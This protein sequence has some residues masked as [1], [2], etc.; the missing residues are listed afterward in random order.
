MN[1]LAARMIEPD[2]EVAIPSESRPTLCVDLDHTLL[3]TD[4]LYEQIALLARQKPAALL[5]L[6][7]WASHGRAALKRRLAKE[8]KLDIGSL[9]FNEE[10]LAWLSEERAQGRRMALYSA[11]D[12]TVVAAVAHH[13]G[14]FDSWAG[15]DGVDNLA[16]SRKAQA[17]H[18]AFGSNFVYAGDHP[19]DVPVFAAGQGAVYVGDVDDLAR[20]LP[21]DHPVEAS[22]PGQSG[23]LKLWA[24]QLRLHQ[25]TKNLLVFVPVLLAGRLAGGQEYLAS[26]LAFFMLSFLASSG[27]VLNDLLDLEADRGHEIKRTRPF[28]SGVLK[29]RDGL[30]AFP[31]LLLAGLGMGLFLPP[32]AIAAGGLYLATTLA[33][34][35]ALKREP[36]LDVMI[37]AGLFTIRLLAGAFAIELPISY[38]L[39]TFS[40]FIFTSLAVVK[41]YAELLKLARRQG[42]V[43]A[44]RGYSTAD[45][46]LLLALGVGTAVAACVIFIIYLINEHFSRAIYTEPGWLWL[47][48]PILHYWLMRVWYLAVHGQ[49]NED[50]VVFAMTDRTSWLLGLAV[51]AVLLLAW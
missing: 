40:M 50:P 25:W 12:E 11:S 48:F 24:K 9:P 13:L 1:A 37:L 35:F 38:W 43:L 44:H 18:E 16:G 17:I 34:S 32:A 33:Y 2:V 42:T 19:R 41:R 8:V 26:V 23:T 6:P 31:L 29:V 45:L 49:M 22:F 14:L 15:S 27:Y 28:A 21:H 4:I 5:A 20:R 39:L 47:A 51:V 7:F 36:M 30:V 46:G 3:R 10:L